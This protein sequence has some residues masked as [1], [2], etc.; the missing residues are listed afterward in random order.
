MG[1][2]TRDWI[3]NMCEPPP[4][5]PIQDLRNPGRGKYQTSPSPGSPS[6]PLL[7]PLLK[8]WGAVAA[9]VVAAAVTAV[10]AVVATAVPPWSAAATTPVAAAPVAVAPVAAAVGRATARNSALLGGWPASGRV[11][12][13]GA[14]LLVWLSSTAL[15]FSSHDLAV[16]PGPS[17]GGSWHPP[18]CYI[19]NRS[20]QKNPAIDKNDKNSGNKRHPSSWNQFTCWTN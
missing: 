20:F 6:S 5:A 14:G 13:D 10:V 7:S 1:Q 12:P 19:T 4:P 3:H 8:R 11:C 2:T 17:R 18:L 9:E 16:S 15:H